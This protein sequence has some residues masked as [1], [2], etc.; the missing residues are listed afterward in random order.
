[1]SQDEYCTCKATLFSKLFIYAHIK[2]SRLKGIMYDLEETTSSLKIIFMKAVQIYI[3]NIPFVHVSL[4]GPLK[5]SGYDGAHS[6]QL[7]NAI[8]LE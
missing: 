2:S 8:S 7:H 6:N 5:V 1:M 4:F 3:L